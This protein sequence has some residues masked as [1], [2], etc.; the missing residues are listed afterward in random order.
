MGRTGASIPPLF[1]ACVR[2]IMFQII[3]GVG[4]GIPCDMV[5][6]IS[7]AK[8]LQ[9]FSLLCHG[10]DRRERFSSQHWHTRNTFF[11]DRGCGWLAAHFELFERITLE[12]RSFQKTR[13]FY[14][15]LFPLARFCIS[16]GFQYKLQHES[17][18]LQ[19]TWEFFTAPENLLC[20]L[21]YGAGQHV[22]N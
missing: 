12:R 21:I 17:V 8:I 6:W 4:L 1:L 9:K 13:N 16:V 22:W 2:E 14:A 19:L 3:D 18:W 20:A 11:S 10:R 7:I 5:F 15:S